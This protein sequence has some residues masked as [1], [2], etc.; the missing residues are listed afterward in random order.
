MCA[1]IA[2]RAAALSGRQPPRESKRRLYNRINPALILFPHRRTLWADRM[3][4]EQ[5]DF[6]SRRRRWGCFRAFC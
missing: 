2:G 6:N 5:A 4:F 1:A 3:R